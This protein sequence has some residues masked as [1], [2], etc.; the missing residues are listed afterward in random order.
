MAS[1]SSDK[2]NHVEPFDITK[3]VRTLD[4]VTRKEKFGPF[5]L[6]DARNHV[7]SSIEIMQDVG[8]IIQRRESL[9]RHQSTAPFELHASTLN[10]MI[11]STLNRNGPQLADPGNS[12]TPISSTPT[13]YHAIIA[14]QDG[15]LERTKD[16]KYRGHVRG[17]V[18]EIS[19]AES[20]PILQF[21]HETL[22]RDQDVQKEIDAHVAML[23]DL[24]R[25]VGAFVEVPEAIK[26]GASE[27]ST[28][29]AN[30][31]TKLSEHKSGPTS[32]SS[33]AAMRHEP[34]KTRVIHD[35]LHMDVRRRGSSVDTR[36][37]P[38]R[39][40]SP[41]PVSRVGDRIGPSQKEKL[42][43]IA[44]LESLIQ[45]GVPWDDMP[46]LYKEEFGIWRSAASFRTVYSQYRDRSKKSTETCAPSQP[47]PQTPTGGADNYGGRRSERNRS[48]T[49]ISTRLKKINA[50]EQEIRYRYSFIKSQLEKGATWDQI[51]AL[52]KEEFGI[53]RT[54]LAIRREYSLD[55]KGRGSKQS[56]LGMGFSLNQRTKNGAG[57]S[58]KRLKSTT[59]ISDRGNKIFATEQEKLHRSDFLL[60]QRREGMEWNELC[61]AYKEK[62]GIMRSAKALMG[63]HK[64]ALESQ[65]D[66]PSL[67][68]SSA[69]DDTN[70][71]SKKRKRSPSPAPATYNEVPPSEEE[72]L[73]R[74]SFMESHRQAGLGWNEI[75]K[76]YHEDFGISRPCRN[77]INWYNYS[78]RKAQTGSSQREHGLESSLFT[79]SLG[80]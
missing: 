76:L 80:I 43:R 26:V 56:S 70:T 31:A 50:S 7:L 4:F 67:R 19:E 27:E 18:V 78:K 68:S 37:N 6:E 35:G 58:S 44:F 16:G 9:K 57:S 28:Q 60:S 74:W 20:Q 66:T 79:S 17:Q 5:S 55:G 3:W 63:Y 32:H 1:M 10:T 29:Q 72:V 8:S 36:E 34:L 54:V 11:S 15:D 21:I 25:Y 2:S 40:R 23:E 22:P 77:L 48:P 52:Y 39:S 30:H 71:R 12:V 61:S 65:E 47:P 13:W 59:P 51:P 24:T 42:H 38:R 45:K 41:T 64:I 46:A 75:A 33:V 73:H 62:F 69:R 49:P 53:W 14:A